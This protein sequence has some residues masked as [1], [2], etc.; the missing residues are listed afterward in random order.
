MKTIPFLAFC[1]C[2]GLVSFGLKN[3]GSSTAASESLDKIGILKLVNA[4]R[5][6]G[7]Q[8]GDTYYYPAPALTW[9]EQL[10]QAAFAH[11]KDMFSKKYFSHTAPDGSRAG[12]RIEKAGYHWLM[13]GENIGLGYKNEKEVVEGWLKSPGHCKNIMN[14]DYKEMGVARAGNYWTQEFGTK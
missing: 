4:A 7:C 12:D 13:Y 9:N 11:S 5:K 1:L 2:F 14:K 6:K 8:C 3:V 10:E